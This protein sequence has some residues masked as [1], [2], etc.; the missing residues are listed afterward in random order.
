[1]VRPREPLAQHGSILQG[2]VSWRCH[3][4][5]STDDSDRERGAGLGTNRANLM[6][7]PNRGRAKVDNKHP[8]VTTDISAQWLKRNLEVEAVAVDII[9]PDLVVGPSANPNIHLGWLVQDGATEHLRED[10]FATVA[11]PDNLCA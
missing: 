8:L 7:E 6:E 11:P 5:G 3:I 9:S 1:M 4:N 10:D 2:A